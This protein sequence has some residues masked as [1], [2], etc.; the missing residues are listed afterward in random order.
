MGSGC[1]DHLGNAYRA[2]ASCRVGDLAP[3]TTSE[4][5]VCVECCRRHRFCRGCFTVVYSKLRS[6]PSLYSP[7]RHS[8]SRAE[9]GNKRTDVLLGSLC[10]WAL[11][12]RAGVE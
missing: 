3:T 2:A 12:Q 11:A 6:V 1:T 9:T 7:A 8:R 4:A 10:T 5:M